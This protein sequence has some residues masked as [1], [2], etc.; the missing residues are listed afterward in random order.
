MDSYH[1]FIFLSCIPRSS[2]SNRRLHVVVSGLWGR[3]VLPLLPHPPMSHRCCSLMGFSCPFQAAS[4]RF[5]MSGVQR[6]SYT[7]TYTRTRTRTRRGLY[8]HP[9]CIYSIYK[10]RNRP[11]RLRVTPG[12]TYDWTRP[13]KKQ[14]VLASR[15]R[16][17]PLSNSG[18]R[19]QTPRA[20]GVRGSRGAPCLA[21]RDHL[22]PRRSRCSLG[23]RRFSS[24]ISFPRRLVRI[25]FSL[26]TLSRCSAGWTSELSGLVS[27]ELKCKRPRPPRRQKVSWL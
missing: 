26:Q 21:P 13:L 15:C 10:Q 27:Q 16:P 7:P 17:D 12:W 3:R 23:A 14:A 19:S 8:P 22:L 4:G 25:R 6:P 2:E 5:S 24:S 1:L 11:Y 20:G 18:S 9:S